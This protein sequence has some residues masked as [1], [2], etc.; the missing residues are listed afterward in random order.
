MWETMWKRLGGA[1][2]IVCVCP[3]MNV[4]QRKVTTSHDPILRSV[5]MFGKGSDERK[6]IS[7]SAYS[8]SQCQWC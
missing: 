1:G 5:G 6:K 3:G 8:P 7:S 4:C 2:Q